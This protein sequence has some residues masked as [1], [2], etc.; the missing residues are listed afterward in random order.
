MP[1]FAVAWQIDDSSAL[2]FSVLA[3]GG[4]NSKYQGGS[5]LLPNAQSKNVQL[6]GTYGNGTTG[7]DLAQMFLGL[8]YAKQ[9]AAQNVSVGISGF[10][11]YQT[12]EA[13]G[14]GNFAGFS[15]DPSKLTNN[16]TDS[17][18]GFGVRIG[19][20]FQPSA[21]LSFGASYQP[22][23]KMNKFND[24]SG[25][26]AQQGRFDIPATWVLGTSYAVN[27][28]AH[29]LFDVQHIAYAD[30]AAVGNPINPLLNGSCTP[31]STGGDGAGCLGAH[32]GAGFGWSNMTVYKLG[33]EWSNDN[34]NTWRVGYSKAEQPIPSSELLF[35]ILAPGVIEQHFTL[36]FGR[37]I[38]SNS[39]F[40]LSLMY[41]PEK[42]VSGV[43]N[44]D[45]GQTIT[46]KMSQVELAATYSV[47]F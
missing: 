18:S 17:A 31:S 25:L 14:L 9:F 24:Y 3:H 6:D 4:M 37:K 29:L 38:D 16:G 27:N 32:S 13:T 46:V 10:M 28:S 35:A 22:Q 39:H 44:F 7:V 20:Q 36:G 15:S 41:A 42:S 23:I 47:G 21:N 5:A 1:Q 34:V 19:L 30:T 40:D 12:F 2:A 8:T 33:Y 45:P 43:N 11:A 26:F